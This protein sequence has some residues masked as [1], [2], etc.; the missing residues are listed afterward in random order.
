[1]RACGLG[2]AKGEMAV[3]SNAPWA[4]PTEPDAGDSPWTSDVLQHWPIGS[5][6]SPKLRQASNVPKGGGGGRGHQATNQLE[7]TKQREN[8]QLSF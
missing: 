3:S 7:A 6:L 8:G 2:A 1:M 4:F 5:A